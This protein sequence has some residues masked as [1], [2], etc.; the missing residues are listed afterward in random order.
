[1]L[2]SRHSFFALLAIA[3]CG[4]PAIAPRSA[5]TPTAH[6]EVAASDRPAPEMPAALS[7]GTEIDP[8]QVGMTVSGVV[9]LCDGELAHAV[10]LLNEIRRLSSAPDSALTWDS[11]LGKFDLAMNAMRTAGDF[12]GLMA[13][14]HPDKSV[15]DAAKTCEPK[16]DRL[17]TAIY[18]D[19]EIASVIKRYAAKNETLSVPRAR[20][21][22][23]LLRDFRRNGLDLDAKGQARLRTLNEELTQL[24]QDFSTN[25]SGA[26]LSLEATPKQLEGLPAAFIAAHPPG[27]NGKVT[28][29][30]DYPDYV[31]VIQY[32]KDRAFA[33][34]LNK[35]FDNRAVKS[36]LPILDKLIALRNEKAHLLG[37]ATWADYVLEPRMAKTSDNVATFL[38]GLRRHIEP[39]ATAEMREYI[40]THVKLGG[41]KGDRLP[42]SDRLYLEDQLRKTKYGFDSKE[43]SKYFEVTR[44]TQGLLDITSK[45]YQIRFQ[46]SVSPTWHPDVQAMDVL[47][48]QGTPI[49]RFYFDLYPRADKYKHAAVFGIRPTRRTSSGERVMPIAG[50]ECNFPRPNAGAPALMSHEDVIVFFHEFGHVLHQ[51]LSES[52]L[53]SFSGT[54][55]A[56][57][58]VESPSQMFEEWA[59]SKETLDL[60]AKHYETGALIPDDLYGAMTRGRAFGR[61]LFTQRQ[62]FLAAV[63]QAYHTRKPGF[64][65]TA[66][67]REMQRRYSTFAY[68]PGTHFQASFGHLVG[69]DGGYYGYQWALAIARDL[70]TRFSAEGILNTTT[71]NDYRAAILAAGGS[72]DEAKMVEH[73]LGR[74][75]NDTAYKKYLLE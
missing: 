40:D 7:T 18:L 58:F 25:I 27:P 6:A 42:L 50:I 5:S 46:P 70:L 49:G 20:L 47:D 75:P 4:R 31:P 22:A 41:K 54:S 13:V 24:G 59:W 29:T 16:V 61:A 62:L 74:T 68:V 55:V 34:S 12:P 35:L 64:D 45:L 44:V 28:I 65:T 48:A 1:M 69:Y 21:L 66:V 37:Y 71:A 43:L 51:M 2:N 17:E 11:A 39:R 67:V 8:V 14:A 9:Q 60:F 30:T 15:R 23:N 26:T 52:E 56:R 72:D 57:D 33:L 32:A 36:N 10:S 73:F 53:A 19:A 3:A 63:D 38:D